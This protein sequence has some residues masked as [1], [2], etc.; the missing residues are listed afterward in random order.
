MICD[1]QGLVDRAEAVLK[2]TKSM[3]HAPD[4]DTLN[5]LSDQVHAAVAD[6]ADAVSPSVIA[7]RQGSLSPPR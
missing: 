2:L 5:D 4:A 6:F 1:D 7:A 3:K